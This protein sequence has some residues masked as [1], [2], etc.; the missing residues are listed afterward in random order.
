MNPT[1]LRAA[2]PFAPLYILALLIGALWLFTGA[3]ALAADNPMVRPPELERDVQFWIRVYTQIDTNSGFLHDQYNL[4]RGVRHAAL[5]AGLLVR[6]ARAAGRRRARS[7]QR[8]AS[9]DRRCGPGAALAGGPAHPRSLGR[10]QPHPRGCARRSMTSASSSARRTASGSGL[11]RSGAWETHIE[12]ALANLGPA[13]GARGAAARRVL[14]QPA[15]LFEGRRGGAV[16]VHALHR[17]ALHAHRQLRS[18]TASIRSAPP[19]R[20]RSCSPTTTGCSA[21]GRWR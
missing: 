10:W 12:E 4:A 18:T 5:P 2:P 16:A 11:I 9:P 14:V 7:L 15:R 8:R 19:R 1:L 3:R 13:R 20:L 6:R 17:P 21:P